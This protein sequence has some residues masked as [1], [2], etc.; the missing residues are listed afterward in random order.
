M[1][2]LFANWVIRIPD[3]QTK[4]SLSKTELGF[5]LI[6]IPIGLILTLTFAGSLIEKLGSKNITILGTTLVHIFLILIIIMPSR[7]F[8]WIVLLF[9]GASISI[10]DMAMNTQGV[11]VERMYKRSIMSSFHASYSLGGFIGSGI[12]FFLIRIGFDPFIHFTFV[13][14]GFFLLAL[15]SFRFLVDHSL[16]KPENN[17]QKTKGILNFPP[18]ILW[19]LG[20]IVFASTIGEAAVADWSAVYLTDVVAT[21]NDI[22]ALG[23][24]AFSLTM[25]FGRLVG[26]NLAN[27]FTSEKVVRYGGIIASLGIFL[28]ILVPELGFVLVGFA[29]MGIGIAVIIPLAFNAAGNKPGINSGVGITAVANIGYMGFL[30]GPP[31]IGFIADNFSLQ[32]AFFIVGCV[33]GTLIFSS[34]SLKIEKRIKI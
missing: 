34:R 30:L 3:I 8:I 26:D 7:T 31:L 29:L 11:V 5:T 9:F 20:F 24:G 17:N 32:T 23:F 25:V 33:I 14:I 13:S 6:A 28:S 12:G 1:G 2:A 22:A 4:F 10:M 16:E 19:P 21:S 27:K 18:K 15:I